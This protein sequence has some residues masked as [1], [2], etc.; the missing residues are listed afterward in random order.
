VTAHG[1]R[2]DVDIENILF[3]TDFSSN[4]EKAGLYAKSL[5]RHYGATVHVVHVV[6]LSAACQ[7]SDAGISIDICRKVGEEKLEEMT[8][9]LVSE[10]IHVAKVLCEGV[11]PAKEVIQIAKHKSVDLI[12]IGTRGLKTLSRLAT[13]SMAEQLIHHAER[14]VLTVGPEA[15][16][17]SQILVFRRIVYATDFSPEAAKAAIY[18][19]SFA[20]DSGAH[21]YLCHVLPETDHKHPVDGK[22]LTE[23]FMAALQGMLPEIASE[24]CEPEC[25]LEHGCAAD[26]ILLVALRLRAD[27]IVLATRPVSHWFDSP[28]AGIA[29]DVI[30][31]ARCPVLTI[32]G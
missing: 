17:P 32:R 29:I 6:D 25:V 3:A 11:N 15:E 31:A 5:A 13:G 9:A 2:V 27:L 14:P 12:V 8:E 20:L 7:A 18:A 24:R 23:E 21:T 22:G 28:K 16:L 19:F 4:A 30:R 1:K 10:N 26:G